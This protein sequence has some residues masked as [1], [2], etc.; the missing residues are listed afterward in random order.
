MSL[1]AAEN[2]RRTPEL[3]LLQAACYCQ[4]LAIIDRNLGAL[5]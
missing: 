2:D 1:L 4:P 5:S 3:T